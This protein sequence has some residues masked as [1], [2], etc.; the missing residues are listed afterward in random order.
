MVLLRKVLI[1]LILY[2]ILVLPVA[3][4]GIN[5]FDGER[6]GE[7]AS[8]GLGFGII[9]IGSENMGLQGDI[10]KGTV[11]FDFRFGYAPN[12]R[13]QLFYKHKS[14]VYL[15]K[16]GEHLDSYFHKVNLKTKKGVGQLVLSPFVVPFIALFTDQHLMGGIG[17]RYYLE[18]KA[19]SWFLESGIGVSHCSDPYERERH[20]PFPSIAD[21]SP[22][23]FGGIGYEFSRHFDAEI[24]FVWSWASETEDN[25]E[26][27]WNALSASFSINLV[28]Y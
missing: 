24:E 15:S 28:G 2:S 14:S 1:C 7:V 9:S 25:F 23:L 10:S 16:L 17:A 4:S 22:G 8:I 5:P 3:K 27:K 26:N 19:P 12:N 21:V 18:P 6:K 13:L 11:V 20:N